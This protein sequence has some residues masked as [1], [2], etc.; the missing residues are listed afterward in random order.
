MLSKSNR[1]YLPVH[2]VLTALAVMSPFLVEAMPL[3]AYGPLT[4]FGNTLESLTQAR[5]YS[6]LLYLNAANP[7]SEDELSDIE[8]RMWAGDILLIDGTESE[9]QTVQAI[10]ASLGGVGLLRPRYHDVQARFCTR[11]IQAN[12]IGQC[13]RQGP[14]PWR[15]KRKTG[16]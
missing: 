12:R 5:A 6:S 7:I 16:L 13:S 4:G 14:Y 10:S 3:S 11:S 8:N 2:L 15:H 9:P 1:N